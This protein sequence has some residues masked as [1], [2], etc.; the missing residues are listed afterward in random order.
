MFAGLLEKL[1]IAEEV[2]KKAVLGKARPRGRQAIAEGR[3]EIG[4]TFISEVL[5]V[6]GV[7]VVGPLP[8]ELHN[9][10]TYTAAIPAG[11]ASPRRGGGFAACAD[12]S[13]HPRALDRGR[14]GAG[15][16]AIRGH[17]CPCIGPGALPNYAM[18]GSA[19]DA[20]DLLKFVVLDEE[21]LEVVSTHLQDAVVKVADVL[22]RR[23]GKAPGG[24]AQPLRLGRRAVRQAGIPPA[25]R[26]VALRAG[27]VVQMPGRQSGRQGRR[28]QSAGGRI[29]RDRC[30]VRRGDDDLFGRR[31]PCGWRSN[32]WRPN[33]P[34][35]ARLGRPRPARPM[36]SMR[37]P[38]PVPAAAKAQRRPH[39]NNKFG[40]EPRE[41]APATP[42]LA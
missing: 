18:D 25:A 2:N 8:G 20:M 3:A 39:C 10:N 4:T 14:A 30:A 38:R 29:F 31:A 34:I 41:P 15:V 26:G 32:A 36:P 42:H 9:A 21:D 19:H 6:K 12:Q 11:S 35:S 40:S 24:G 7:K 1:G 13:R 16:L 27:A 22:W 17:L 23:A 33:W 28:A 5:P 37:P